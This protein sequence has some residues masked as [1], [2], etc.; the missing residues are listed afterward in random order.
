[1]LHT[2]SFYEIVGALFPETRFDHPS[3]T[4]RDSATE[5][6]KKW[7]ISVSYSSV[8][9]A[10]R[11]VHKECQKGRSHTVKSS[12]ANPNIYDVR[13][14]PQPKPNATPEKPDAT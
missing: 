12:N 13:N 14:D 6:G 5:R 8:A 1:M 7:K 3:K 9:A 2:I 11:Q 4:P 10:K